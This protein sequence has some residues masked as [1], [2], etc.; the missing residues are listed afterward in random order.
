MFKTIERCSLHAWPALQT[1]CE[2][3]WLLRF[4]EGYTK[5]ANSVNAF[6]SGNEA[7]LAAKIAAFEKRYADAGLDSVFKITPFVPESLDTELARQGYT[8]VE[9]SCVQLLDG[10]DQIGEPKLPDVNMQ[11]D[12]SPEW[13]RL[14]SAMSGLSGKQ[15]EVMQRMLASSELTTGYF[16]LSHLSVP[17]ACGIGVVEGEYVGLFDIVTAKQYRNRGYAEQLIL[18]ILKW[19]KSCGA[20]KSYV[21]VVESNAPAMRLYEK[22]KYKQIYPY[23]YRV[24]TIAQIEEEQKPAAAWKEWLSRFPSIQSKTVSS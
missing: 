4:A 22:L 14:V 18:H 6:D 15:A 20:S 13:L 5:R 8:V 24:K 9:P 21:Q 10:L 11:R 19:G 12:L 17:V 16:V 2:D 7:D 3:G 1:T 23:W